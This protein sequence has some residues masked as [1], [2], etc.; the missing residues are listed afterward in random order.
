MVLGIMQIT[1]SNMRRD[2]SLPRSHCFQNVRVHYDLIEKGLM[3]QLNYIDSAAGSETQNKN[4]L[5]MTKLYFSL[6]TN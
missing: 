5:N 1:L 4:F 3:N 2:S 6:I